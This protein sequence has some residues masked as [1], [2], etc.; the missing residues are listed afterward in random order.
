MLINWNYL[1]MLVLWFDWKI[2]V[3]LHNLA[4]LWGL[5]LGLDIFKHW[6]TTNLI[7][8]ENSH[9][10]LSQN[11]HL[12]RGESWVIYKTVLWR[13]LENGSERGEWTRPY[14]KISTLYISL[15]IENICVPVWLPA[16]AATWQADIEL[17]QRRKRIQGHN[18]Q[19]PAAGKVCQFCFSPAHCPLFLEVLRG[20]MILQPGTVLNTKIAVRVTRFKINIFK[21]R[22]SILF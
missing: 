3:L 22:R 17:R 16:T 4:V 20:L 6:Q 18:R 2:V 1:K 7:F 19:S 8:C 14:L 9:T 13:N 12:S 10:Q 5:G 11:I 21:T 15:L